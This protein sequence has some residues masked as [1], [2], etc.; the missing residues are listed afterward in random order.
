MRRRRLLFAAVAL[1][2]VGA[3]CDL[4]NLFPPG[5][6]PLR[7]RDP[8][9]TTVVKTAD[10]TYGSA[11]NLSGQTVTLKLDVYKPPLNDTITSRPAIVWVHGGS[12]SNGDKTSAE[13]VDESNNFAKQGYVN[14]SI[15]YRL[16]PGGCSAGGPTP[17]C[18][19]AILEAKQD[20]QTAVSFLRTNAAT[21]GIDPTRIAIGG[22]SAGAI[23]AL[24]VGY[25]TAET[26]ASA[27]RAAVSLSGANLFSTIGAGDAPAL[28]FHGTADTVVPYQWAVSTVNHAKEAHLDV[29]L[30]SWEG[31]GHVPYVQF[32]DQILTQT[33]NFLWWEMN[34]EHAAR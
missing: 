4:P 2:V 11:V 14:A 24:H 17:E 16:E 29:F 10:I 21:Y 20:A 12:F 6:A 19:Q 3:G 8:I 18:I 5:S 34:L 25:A 15:N 7:Y 28:L 26:P 32:R 13:L 31:A 9:F 23:T 22:T 27:V 1:V 33:R 30:E